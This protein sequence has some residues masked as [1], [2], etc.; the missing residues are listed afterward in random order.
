[1]LLP[2]LK[3]AY[4][5]IVSNTWTNGRV[6]NAGA[7]NKTLISNTAGHMPKGWGGGRLSDFDG[8]F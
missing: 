3:L 2:K 4:N 7:Q 1:M 6:H 8:G 5:I